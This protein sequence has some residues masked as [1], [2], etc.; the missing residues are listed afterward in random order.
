MRRKCKGKPYSMST[1]KKSSRGKKIREANN[2]TEIAKMRG[3]D[4]VRSKGR[5][6]KLA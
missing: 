4:I 2:P 5:K 3:R 1:A 6:S